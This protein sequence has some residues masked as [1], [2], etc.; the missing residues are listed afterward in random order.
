MNK[1]WLFLL[2]SIFLFSKELDIKEN[3]SDILDIKSNSYIYTI[4][5]FSSKTLP[6]AERFA[7]N[8]DKDIQKD[9]FILKIGSYY[10]VRYKNEKKY[11][12]LKQ[13]LKNLKKYGFND[14]FIVKMDE[15]RL[16]KAIRYT[17]EKTFNKNSDKKN[18][19]DTTLILLDADNFYKAGKYHKSLNY[20]L[21]AYRL[22]NRSENIVI[23]I[24]YL[25]GKTCNLKKFENFINEI[26]DKEPSVYAFGIGAIEVEEDNILK[27]LL[28]KN[29]DFSQEGYIELLLGYIYEKEKDFKNAL[30]F[31]KNAYLKNSKDP[32]F[33]YAYARALDLDKRYKKAL[34]YYKYLLKNSDNNLKKTVKKRVETLKV[35]IK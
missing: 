7:K 9:S 35:L 20:Y 32:Y 8:L 5:L 23:N 17:S 2:I 27:D 28:L 22:G 12:Y 29:I 16:L 34:R 18:K 33:V 13:I 26:D 24:S 4:Q 11:N 10:V 19:T 31:Y 14:A 15:R 1:I 3:K 30:H 21:K 25:M 6:P